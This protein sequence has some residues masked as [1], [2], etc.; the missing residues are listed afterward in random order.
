MN[1]KR[2][3]AILLLCAAVIIYTAIISPVNV[4]AKT[5]AIT[6]ATDNEYVVFTEK[7]I[8]TEDMRKKSKLDENKLSEYMKKFPK[9][10]GIEN[11]LMKIQDEYNVNALLILA[12]IRLESGNGKSQI[13][14][15]KNNLGGIIAS[16]KSVRVYK[17]FDTRSDCVIYMAELLSGNYLT[18]GGKY[19]KGYTLTDIA[20]SYSMSPDEWSELVKE[21]IYEI[22]TD[23][24]GIQSKN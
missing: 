22:Q 18:E 19:F 23:I 9:L 21:L 8:K 24:D 14:Q 16:H 4:Y 1:M 3:H 15:S 7:N 2:N 20:K 5:D 6:T 13:A 10:S 12:I 11:T 17:S